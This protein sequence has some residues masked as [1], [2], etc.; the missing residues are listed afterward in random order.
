MA[1][2][3]SLFLLLLLIVT[4]VAGKL[5]YIKRKRPVMHPQT[6]NQIEQINIKFGRFRLH[7]LKL[8]Q[9]NEG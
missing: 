7:E 4:V 9:I 5:L 3:C 1:K 6:E 8:D 2:G